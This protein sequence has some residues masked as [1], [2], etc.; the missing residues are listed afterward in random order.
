MLSPLKIIG[1]AGSL[2]VLASC[3][4][5]DTS[6]SGGRTYTTQNN[7]VTTI[8]GTAGA[9][10]SA[11]GTAALARFSFPFGITLDGANLY[12]ADTYNNTVRKIVISTGAV[13][14]IA[15]TAGTTGSADGTGTAATFLSPT[16]ITTD[17]TNLYLTDYGN[18]TIRKIVISSGAVTTIAGTAGAKGSA[19]G[20]GTAATFN[21]PAGITTDGTN[22]YLTDYGNNTVRK[23]VIST[24]AVTTIAGTA[25]AVGLADGTGAT[26]TFSFPFGITTDGTNLY[27]ADS[28]Y[29]TIRKIVISTR[30]VT[31][32]AGTAGA[33]GSADGTGAAATF[34]YPLGI[35]TDG[36]NLYV[37]DTDNSMIRRIVISTGAVA[38]IAGNVTAIGSADGT[39]A[40]ATFFY[41]AGI[42][43]DGTN[44][45]VADTNNSTIRKIY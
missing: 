14:T 9:W 30:A 6:S 18:S 2:I 35:T 22:L 42:T 17:G 41:P 31:T 20:T 34:F 21:L 19:D 13:T 27:V 8:A 10:G 23:I 1:L 26:A 39:G 45:Y 12:V 29:S 3:G 33:L 38:T 24:G 4:G 43:T 5:G 11:D 7:N 40:A 36:T 25:G 44:L 15:G 32:I 28:F 16:G 37:A